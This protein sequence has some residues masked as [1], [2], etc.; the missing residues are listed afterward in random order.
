MSLRNSWNPSTRSADA[1]AHAA[2]VRREHQQ[3]ARLR[4]EVQLRALARH[5]TPVRVVPERQRRDRLVLRRLDAPRDQRVHAI[6]TDRLSAP[7]PIRT[8]RSPARRGSPFTRPSS[9]ISSFTEKP[10]RSSAPAATAAST[11]IL[12]S[13]MRRGHQRRERLVRQAR[14]AAK[15]H[16]HP[17][18]IFTLVIGGAGRLLQLRHQAPALEARRRPAAG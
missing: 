12:S 8:H 13:T 15:R 4:D 3:A 5:A 10:S 7:L 9:M 11:S 14:R 1:D 2:V 17:C 6:G 18:R 16:A